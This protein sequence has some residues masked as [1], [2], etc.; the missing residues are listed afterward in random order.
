MFCEVDGLAI[1]YETYGE[2][3]PVLLIHGFGID[4]HVMIGCMEPVFRDR[5]GYKRIYF[6]LPGMGK[7]KAVDA[8][9]SSDQ[10]LDAVI[11]FAEKV[12][13]GDNF[14][15]AGESYGGYLAR[16]LVSRIP[17]R[18]AGLLLICPV[19]Y[20]DREKRTLP[21]RA[22]FAR[23]E[24]MLADIEPHTRAFF[25]RMLVLQDKRRWERFQEDIVPGTEAEDREFT[26]RLMET[27]YAFSFDADRLERPFEKPSL[28]LA[29]RQDATVGWADMLKI[30]DNY[31]RGTFA[32]LDRAGHGLEVEQQTVFECLVNEWLDRVEEEYDRTH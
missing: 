6:D 3:I 5:P 14:L 10:M 17:D 29:G 7:T 16:G 11:R 24:Q 18:L 30:V 25:E 27:G 1:Y 4:H 13:P 20:A 26:K 19:I 22:V 12:I 8:I 2:G 9:E 31:P 21:Q 23:D 32:V 15:V 28:L